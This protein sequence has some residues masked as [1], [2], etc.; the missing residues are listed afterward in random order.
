MCGRVAFTRLAE[1]LQYLEIEDVDEAHIRTTDDGRPTTLLPVVTGDDPKAL[2]AFR[3]GLIPPWTKPEADG[4]LPRWVQSTFNAVSEEVEKKPAFRSAFKSQ[5][6]LVPVDGFFEWSYPGGLR[7]SGKG[8]KHFFSRADGHPLVFAGLWERWQGT[9]GEVKSF[10]ILTCA[11]NRFMSSYHDRMPVVLHQPDFERWLHGHVDE[12]RE[13]MT[14]CGEHE[15]TVNPPLISQGS[16][17]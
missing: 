7:K 1:V 15:L 9:E 16:L 2:R 8:I 10:T 14:A 4:K 17:L 3:W 5:R 11:P 13:L 6:C 12:V